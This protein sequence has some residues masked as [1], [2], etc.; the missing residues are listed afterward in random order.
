MNVWWTSMKNCLNLSL[1]NTFVFMADASN[2]MTHLQNQMIK[3]EVPRL[4]SYINC[5]GLKF[6][7]NISCTFSN[8]ESSCCWPKKGE[9]FPHGQ[10]N[11]CEYLFYL[12]FLFC[13]SARRFR[14]EISLHLLHGSYWGQQHC[15]LWWTPLDTQTRLEQRHPFLIQIQYSRWE[16]TM[17]DWTSFWDATRWNS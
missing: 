8:W 10:K 16:N 9:S 17:Q 5:R 12:C 1:A 6:I 4:L 14:Y 13:C 15:C 7:L 11:L 3:K 2:L